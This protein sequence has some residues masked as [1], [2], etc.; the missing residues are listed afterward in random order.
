M[1]HIS[2]VAPPPP[3]PPMVR[4]PVTPSAAKELP[5]GVNI[6][7]DECS[8]AWEYPE[9]QKG[10]YL[11]RVCQYAPPKHCQ[12]YPVKSILQVS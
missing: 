5:V 3:P 7:T 10:C 2:Q 11:S 4:S 8:W 9:L 12:Y 6:T 1:S